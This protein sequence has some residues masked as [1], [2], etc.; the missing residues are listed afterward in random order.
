MKKA[1]ILTLTLLTLNSSA[2]N[3]FFIGEKGYPSAESFSLSQNTEGN[4]EGG[5]QCVIARKGSTGIIAFSLKTMTEVVIG[6]NV[7]MYLN[8]GSTITL[9]DRSIYDYVDETAT[10]VYY[11]TTNEIEKL[12]KVNL[13]KVR[14]ALKCIGCISSEEGNFTASNKTDVPSLI[15][16]LFNTP[17]K[18]PRPFLNL[19]TGWQRLYIDNCGSIDIPPT[20]EIQSSKYRNTEYYKKAMQAIE[21]DTTQFIIQQKGLNEHESDALNKY[22]RIIIET[23]LGNEGQYERLTFDI[24]TISQE[25]I[26]EL[27]KILK[28]QTL[29]D[30]GEAFKLIEWNPVKVERINGMACVHANYKRKFNDAPIVWVHVYMFQ[31]YSMVNKLTLS[32]RISESTYWE[33]DFERIL[34]SFRILKIK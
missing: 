29:T 10:T 25:E 4:F 2:Q 26:I 13:N 12:K 16:N 28:E 23:T 6:G 22:A 18:L 24:S 21:I 19:E 1:F 5:L 20:M 31:N 9:I 27:D 11:L 32:Y 33:S 8:D 3:L 7:T 30:G 15:V 34:K 17:Q 14:Y